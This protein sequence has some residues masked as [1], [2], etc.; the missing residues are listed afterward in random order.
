MS[1]DSVDFEVLLSWVP[2]DE[3]FQVTVFYNAPGDR[4]DYRFFK[5]DPVRFDLAYLTELRDASIDDYG[6]ALGAMLFPRECRTLLQQ[7]IGDATDLP[8]HLRLIIDAKAPAVYQSLRWETVCHPDTG[9]RLTTSPR[10]RF[11]RFIANVPGGTQ[12]SVLPRSGKLRA[13]VAVAN[14]TDL[15]DMIRGP[16]RLAPI[17]VEEEVE[18]ATT[19]LAGMR[20]DVQ[21]LGGANRAPASPANILKALST[22]LQVLYIVCH[23]V[24]DEGRSYLLLEDAEGAGD[25]VDGVA[26]ANDIGDLDRVPTIVVLCA[27]Q[28]A[29]RDEPRMERTAENLLAVAPAIAQAG[30]AVVIGM[31]G[32]VTMSTAATFLP[33]FFDELNTDGIPA[34]AMA[35]ARR[36][37]RGRPDWYMPVLYSRLKRGRS[38]YLPRF[39]AHG[40]TIFTNLHRRIN[41]GHCIPII[42]SGIAG[43]DEV[44]P[45][46]QDFAAEW[47]RR[48]QIPME[49]S[50]KTDLASV[51]QFVSVEEASGPSL[52]QDE[53]YFLLRN[54]LRSK[55]HGVLPQLDWDTLPIATLVSLVGEYRR[56][57]SG[58]TDGY[59]RLARLDL[60]VFV[61]TSWSNL[62]EEAMVEAGKKPVTRYF[63]W[64]KSTGG[65]EWPYLLPGQTGDDGSHQS[66]VSDTGALTAARKLQ[67][68]A[69]ETHQQKIDRL[70]QEI[71]LTT[72]RDGGPE[73]AVFRLAAG[74]FGVHSPL[75]YHLFGT[76]QVQPTLVI[77]EDDYFTWLREWIKQSDNGD[78]IPGYVKTALISNSQLFLGYQF[79]DWEFRMVFQCIKSFQ[80]KIQNGKPHVGVQIEPQ[81]LRVEREAA[82]NYLES[83]FGEDDITVY[84]QTS[85]DFLTELDRTRIP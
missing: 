8:V 16:L 65:L 64:R 34:R 28:S 26:F 38:W 22:P 23:G 61:T 78:S 67:G 54:E 4:D 14:P 45:S 58:G 20:M 32:D 59:S 46:R 18:R 41:A 2:R 50:S 7:A 12:P 29:G 66:I 70:R 5:P 77:T 74:G 56:G 17:E 9:A 53:L 69:A 52:V 60:P 44:V 1:T 31:Q 49:E 43:E 36:S 11:S 10:I 13:L 72:P 82:Q 73:D 3:G 24:S 83:Y 81:S 84:W 33:T 27:C 19:A 6:V 62:L 35:I 79:D 85:S 47:V 76:L 75:V 71:H 80:R 57:R 51:A 30:V 48:R 39:G 68:D 37:V 55:Y 21:V 63:D 40:N 25:L 42:G 15:S